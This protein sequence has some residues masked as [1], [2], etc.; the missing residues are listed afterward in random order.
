MTNQSA[1]EL[2]ENLFNK[3]KNQ[4][5]FKIISNAYFDDDFV[6]IGAV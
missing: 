2:F 3:M 5:F 4:N 1:K 6:I